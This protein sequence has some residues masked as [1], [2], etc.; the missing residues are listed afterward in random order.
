MINV[1]SWRLSY[2]VCVRFFNYGSVLKKSNLTKNICLNVQGQDFFA[3]FFSLSRSQVINLIFLS[4]DVFSFKPTFWQK[5]C[6][7]MTSSWRRERIKEPENPFSL[8]YFWIW[9]GISSVQSKT[10]KESWFRRVLKSGI[11][12]GSFFHFYFRTLWY[13]KGKK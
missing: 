5:K 3:S 4:N 13:G 6:H 2:W 12:T 10:S 7:L 11:I 8:L 1:R 9:L